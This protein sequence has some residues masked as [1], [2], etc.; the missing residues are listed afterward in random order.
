MVKLF[1]KHSCVEDWCPQPSLAENKYLCK[2]VHFC[3]LEFNFGKE[4]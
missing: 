1:W 2:E 3:L 4:V